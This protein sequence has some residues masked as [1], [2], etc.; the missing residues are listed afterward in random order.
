[1]FFIP[2]N[3]PEDWRGLLADPDKHWKKGRSAKALA[4]SWQN[5]LW[6]PSEVCAVFKK[7]NL[8]I[9]QDIELLFAFPEF[10]VNLPGGSRPSQNDIFV[11]AK[12][13]SELIAIA[14]EGKV[15]EEFDVK[16]KDWTKKKNGNKQ[17]FLLSAHY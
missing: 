2:A 6:F 12:G 14:V 11:L 17:D 10:K 13:N 3:E 15:T 9:F 4:Y 8:K 7:S 1:M 5:S 16:V